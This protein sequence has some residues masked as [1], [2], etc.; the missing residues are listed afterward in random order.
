MAKNSLDQIR[1]AVVRDLQALIQ[2][3]VISPADEDYGNARKVWNGAVDHHPAAIAFCKSTADVQAAVRTARAHGLP[4]SVRAAGHDA[5]GRSV[6]SGAL[7]IDLSFMNQVEVNGQTATVAGGA[8]SAKVIAA[9]A[10]NGLL[11]VTGWNGVPG[12]TGLTTVGGYGPLIANHGLAL[13]SLTGAELVLADGQ[14]ISV[15]SNNNPD[16]LWALQGGGGNFGVVTSIT[17]RLHPLRQ[18]LGGMILFPWSDAEAVLKSYAGTMISA[19]NDLTVVIGILSLP[20]GNPA[21]FL[22][23]AWTGEMTQGEIFMDVL[24]RF[25]TPIYAQ[26]GLMSYQDL[27]QSF[28]ARVVNGRHYALETR[29]VPALTREVISAVVAGG[30][31]RSSPFSVIILQHFR[32]AP[33]QTSLDATAFGLRREHFLIEM[34]A[35]WDASAGDDGASH[36]SWARDLCSTLAPMSLPG[37]YPNILGLHAHDQIAHAYGSNLV[38]L[39]TVKRRFDPDGLFSA[40]PLPV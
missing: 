7:V 32:G 30:A 17:I 29:W 8:T 15:D 20:D 21:L 27:V 13:D 38:R 31:G 14:H 36:R 26:I 18:V 34:I 1:N 28:D 39:Q 9:A 16:L 33:T 4:V 3:R 10:A 40:T 12:M 5:A 11:A 35:S 37:G 6:R 22:A 23:P 25:G 24:Q 19:S 2:G